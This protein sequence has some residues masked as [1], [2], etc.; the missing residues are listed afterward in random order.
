MLELVAG[1]LLLFEISEVLL[2]IIE[3]I[4]AVTDHVLLKVEVVEAAA[5]FILEPYWLSV[6][7]AEAWK[8]SERGHGAAATHVLVHFWLWFRFCLVLVGFL[9]VFL[10]FLAVHLSRRGVWRGHLWAGTDALFV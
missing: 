8:V 4:R 5:V 9:L 10:R 6:G 3:L 1:L 2:C 7:L